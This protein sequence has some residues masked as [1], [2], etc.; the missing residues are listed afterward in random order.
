MGYRIGKSLKLWLIVVKE[1]KERE[2][3][4][5]MLV[6]RHTDQF[7]HLNVVVVLIFIVITRFN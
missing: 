2:Y 4:L 6:N 1:R 5:N 7:Q 3:R